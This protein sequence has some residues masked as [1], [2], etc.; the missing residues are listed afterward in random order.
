MVSIKV[1]DITG[2]EL[3]TLKDDYTVAGTHTVN[4]NASR[5]PSG[6]YLLQMKSGSF[7]KTQKIVLMK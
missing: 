5:Y 3:V 2:R 7:S 1:F 6:V 4:W